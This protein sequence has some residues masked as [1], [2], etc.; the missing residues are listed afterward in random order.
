[1]KN[2]N[3]IIQKDINKLSKNLMT[4]QEEIYELDLKL[5]VLL[6]LNVV[7]FIIWMTISPL[8]LRKRNP[9]QIKKKSTK[10]VNP[11]SKKGFLKNGLYA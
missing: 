1:M 6:T 7:A 10:K 8:I 2:K 9:P 5:F 11:I 4:L 3:E